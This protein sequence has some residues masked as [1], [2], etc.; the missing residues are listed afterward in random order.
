MMARRDLIKGGLG[1]LGVLAAGGGALPALAQS[2][3]VPLSAL[4]AGN[5]D[6]SMAKVL[7][8]SERIAIPSY[9]FGM[10]L[11]SGVSA[12]GSSGEVTTELA[13]DLVGVDA[14]MLRGI[15][16]QMF[17]DFVERLRATGRTLVGWNEIQGS[18]A[19]K[20]FQISQ[21]PFVKRP[22]TDART[23]AVV[24]PEYLPLINVHL[25]APLSD[26]S[27]LSLGNW[28]AINALSVETKSLV[29]IPR[30]VFDFAALT[31]S[32]HRVYGS[33][34]S[35]GI[36]PG[37]HLVPVFTQFQFYHAKIAL[38][39]EGGRLVLEDRIAVG[40]A[41][42]LVK[43][44]SFN[45]RDEVE[46]WN[47]YARSNAWWSGPNPA[48][49]RPSRAYDFSTYQYRVDPSQLTSAI[50]DAA[51]SAHGVFMGVINA[52]RPA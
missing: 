10:V 23:V 24:T 33:S 47:S 29:M 44:G 7:A 31:G 35:V 14:A 37:L 11:R 5:F 17:S 28:R 15:A 43:T 48:P 42:E 4:S 13:A 38:A 22:F 25:D 9:R 50:L 1:T 49:D 3:M 19:F 41:G 34:A 30:L 52:N 45:N 21:D 51:R 40:Q 39:G 27:P 2:K 8:R 18:A 16:H 46:R 36:Q 12:T 6:H 26:Q 20:K 32:G